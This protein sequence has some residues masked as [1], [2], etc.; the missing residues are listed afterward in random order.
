MPMLVIKSPG[1]IKNEGGS[2]NKKKKKGCC[3]ECKFYIRPDGIVVKP[4][5]TNGLQ[6]NDKPVYNQS[7]WWCNNKKATRY[8]KKVRGAENCQDYSNK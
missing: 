2:M 3:Y 7:G 5:W 4:I 8:N 6:P 1:G